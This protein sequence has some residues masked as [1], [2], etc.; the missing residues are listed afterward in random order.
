[1]SRSYKKYPK[2]KISRYGKSGK[3]GK[4]QANR[5]IRRLPIEEHIPDG[6]CFTKYHERSEIVDY[7]FTQFKEWE[8]DEWN[9][10]QQEIANNVNTWKTKY[11]TSL[12]EALSNWKKFY[13][14]K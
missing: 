14:C 11:N 13:K 7:S 4:K 3:Y 1:M 8:I 9:R 2:V 6:R 5:T 12:E 10:D